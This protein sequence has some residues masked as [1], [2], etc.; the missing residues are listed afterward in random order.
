[1]TLIDKAGGA[2]SFPGAS[3]RA[4]R[5]QLRPFLTYSL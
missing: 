3:L 5:L 4:Q 2:L 1:M